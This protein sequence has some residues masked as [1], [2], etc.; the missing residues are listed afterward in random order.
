[1]LFK[2]LDHVEINTDQPE[3][4]LAFYTGVLGFS[5]KSSHTVDGASP[6]SR[7]SIVYLSLGDTGVELIS[8]EGTPIAP[9]PAGEQLGYRGMALEVTDM[10]RAVEFLQSKGVEVIW[11]PHTKP[12]QYARAEIL[13]PHGYHIEL[14]QWF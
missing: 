1:M 10:D 13:D 9:A 4:A 7:I 5:V 3:R 8:H 6:G 2:K 12:G 11:G 14:R